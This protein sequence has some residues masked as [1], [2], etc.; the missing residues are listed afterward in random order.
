VSQ[1]CGGVAD[2]GGIGGRYFAKA[3]STC[4]S[5]ASR[6][7]RAGHHL[8]RMKNIE[9]SD[10]EA[11]ALI[12]E[13]PQLINHAKYPFSDRVRT[14]SAILARLRPE[15]L[16]EPSPPPEHYERLRFIRG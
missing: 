10:E 12:G 7:R 14:L 8:S 1:A 2:G 16:R 13:L 11:V 9:L 4:G 5:A 15:P 3:S 6:Q